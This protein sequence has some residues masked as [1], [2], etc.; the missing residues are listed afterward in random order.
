MNPYYVNNYKE[1][2]RSYISDVVNEYWLDLTFDN[3][4][5]IKVGIRDVMGSNYQSEH[6]WQH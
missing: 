6:I 2:L 5:G 3:Y 1:D 4:K